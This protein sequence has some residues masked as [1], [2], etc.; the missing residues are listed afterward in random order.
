MLLLRRAGVYLMVAALS[1][2]AMMASAA[3][4]S[5]RVP[6]PRANVAPRMRLPCVEIVQHVDHMRSRRPT[7]QVEV[8]DVGRALNQDFRWVERCMLLYGRRPLKP[9]PVHEEIREEED[10]QWEDGE[11]DEIGPEQTGDAKED[12]LHLES[13]RHQKVKPTPSPPALGP[14]E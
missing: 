1:T 7:R 9:A 10:A 13:Q 2:L 6:T 8:V 4:L 11:A 3:T 5:E 14:E 12:E